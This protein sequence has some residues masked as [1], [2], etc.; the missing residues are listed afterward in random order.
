VRERAAIGAEARI[1]PGA[2]VDNDV[3]VGAR[4]VLESGAYLTAAS[5]AEA[6]VVLGADVVTTNDDTM[7]RHAPGE[8]LMGVVLRRGCRIGARA[9]LVPGVEVGAGSIVA[10]DSVVTRDVPAGAR[11]EGVPA[12]PVAPARGGES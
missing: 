4:T 5:V 1:G 6:D 2:T 12:R 7:G 8:A 9:V 3:E 11:V 10:A